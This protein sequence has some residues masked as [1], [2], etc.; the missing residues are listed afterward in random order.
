MGRPFGGDFDLL[1]ARVNNPF[2]AMPWSPKLSKP[3]TLGGRPEDNEAVVRSD[4][5]WKAVVDPIGVQNATFFLQA[6]SLRRVAW[7]GL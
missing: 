6:Q 5:R 3:I 2:S 4:C 1:D 7:A